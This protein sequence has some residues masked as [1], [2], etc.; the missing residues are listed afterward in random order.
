MSSGK[1]LTFI[2][3]APRFDEYSGG[4]IALHRLCHLLRCAGESAYLWQMGKPSPRV[5]GGLSLKARQAYF[6]L[7]ARRN[8]PFH[9]R[10]DFDSPV[11]SVAQLNNAIVV[12]PETVSGDPLG[13]GRCVRWFLHRPGFHTGSVDYG[14]DDLMFYYQDAFKDESTGLMD[15]G[16]L[17]TL[18]VR[19]DVYTPPSSGERE[20]ECYMIR[21]AEPDQHVHHPDALCLDGLSHEAIAREFQHRER[22]I[23]Y[24][25]Y[26][27]YSCYAAACG[28]DSIVVP[29][30][31][32]DKS[33][34]HPDERKRYGLAYGVDDLDW[35][36]STRHR[37]LEYMKFEEREAAESVVRFVATC[38]DFFGSQA[39]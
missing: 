34:W 23:C 25:L 3:Y 31:Q 4:A 21:K 35:A 19:D 10:A 1:E 7:L 37:A 32:V 14:D 18:W 12:Y 2:I 22:F 17:Q 29:D 15:G 5:Y 6:S 30:P 8:G 39:P 13:T 36:R 16:W 26:T 28:C 9:R 27:L 38:R 24:D 11:A 20:G 33:A